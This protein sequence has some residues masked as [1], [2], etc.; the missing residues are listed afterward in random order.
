MVQP[1]PVTAFSALSL[2][3]SL[4]AGLDALGYV[5]MTDVQAKALPDILAGKDVLLQGEPGSGKTAIFGLAMLAKLE[6]P[7]ARPQ[8]LVL[9][10]TRE[11]AE[12]IAEEVRRLARCTPNIKVLVLCGGTP[13]GAQRDSLAQGAHIVVGTPG[14]LD[15]HLRKDSLVLDRL[16]VLVIDEADRM[17]DMGFE[18]QLARVVARAPEA[19]QTLLFSATYPES[20][21]RL[22]QSYQRAALLI[23]VPPSS[24][25]GSPAGAASGE[26]GA[27]SAVSLVEQ[28]FYRVPSA[29]RLATLEAWLSLE[30]PESTLVFSS[31]R[32]EAHDVAAELTRKGWV[33]TCIHGELH[34]RD[35][36]HAMR[37][38]ANRSC[39]VLAATDVAARGWDITGLSAIV[40]LGLS[41][42]A[43]VHLHRIGRTGRSGHAGLAISLVSDED[44]GHLRAIEHL[45]GYP[46]T[47][48]DPPAAPATSPPVS[49][50]MVTLLLRC[51]KDKKLRAG[52][53]LGA[54]TAEGG[55]DAGDVGLIQIDDRFTYVAVRHSVAERALSRLTQG[56]IKGRRVKVER[57]GLGF[58]Q[59]A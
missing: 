51:G 20:V 53:V 8:G 36:Q 21:I 34:Q 56:P 37:L 30:R 43:R 47:L 17:L 5:A 6:G 9:C 52:D 57:A 49:P 38:F 12:Q 15:E 3:A 14:R 29:R 50:P 59:P 45:Q 58:R 13:F 19:R 18:P 23:E 11:L 35:R 2:P 42:D 1:H 25:F 48:L 39:S 16:A 44:A 10:P 40:N 7:P 24:P 33:A 32:Q 4:L 22:S 27:P 31:T 26:P 41:R 55:I 46:V 54:L 28:R